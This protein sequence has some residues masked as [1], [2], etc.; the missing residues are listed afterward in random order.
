MNYHDRKFRPK[1]TSQGSNVSGETLFHYQQ[2]GHIVTSFYSGGDIVQGHLI[3][4][5]DSGGVL[6]M[7]YHHINTEGQLM[8]GTCISKPEQLPDGR[9]VL[10]EEWQWT[11]GDKS[12]GTSILEEVE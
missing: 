3:A 2:K 7:R 12:S 5:V 6:D 4:T 8:T 1:T 9:I 11:S 10:Y